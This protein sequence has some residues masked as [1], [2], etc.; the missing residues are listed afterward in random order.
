MLNRPEHPL[1]VRHH[2]RHPSIPGGQA[3][4]TRYRAVRVKWIALCGMPI[5]A[6]ITQCDHTVLLQVGRRF[7]AGKLNT[8]FTVGDSDRH[9]RARHT[10]KE[11]GG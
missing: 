6:D 7:S 10:I 8:P 3:G 11:N 5:V 2:D 1:R 4:N 9:S